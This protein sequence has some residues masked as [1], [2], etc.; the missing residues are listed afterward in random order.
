MFSVWLTKLNVCFK[1]YR[2]KTSQSYFLYLNMV[3][4][5]VTAYWISGS[6]VLVIRIV[7]GRGGPHTFYCGCHETAE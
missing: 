4:I 3:V 2:N 1:V 7:N 6:D 5:L